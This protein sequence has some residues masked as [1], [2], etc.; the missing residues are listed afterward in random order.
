MFSFWS[1][2][3]SRGRERSCLYD[4]E[5]ESGFLVQLAGSVTY[6]SGRWPIFRKIA[7][8]VSILVAVDSLSFHFLESWNDV[9]GWA[10]IPFLFFFFFFLFT[11]TAKERKRRSRCTEMESSWL[12]FAAHLRGD[13]E[14]GNRYRRFLVL[15]WV[16]RGI[17]R[18]ILRTGVSWIIA[19]KHLDE[20]RSGEAVRWEWKAV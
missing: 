1:R 15:R 17:S 2:F 6:V 20:L 10:D 4:L 14:D 13:F 16:A 8:S 12:M 19:D 5:K 18:R 11:R 7:R 3:P 9:D